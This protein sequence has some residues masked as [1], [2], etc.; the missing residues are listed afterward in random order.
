MTNSEYSIEV[1]IFSHATSH[2]QKTAIID[3]KGD[4]VSYSNLWEN[5]RLAANALYSLGLKKGERIILSASKSV[6]F[7]F[8]Y[9]GAHIL[10]AIV[11]PVDPEANSTRMDRIINATKPKFIFGDLRNVKNYNVVP[12]SEIL[13]QSINIVSLNLP[14]AQQPADIL[15]TTGTTGFPKGVVLT[16]SNEFHAA[17]N[18][19]EFIGNNSDDIE[20]LAL[21]ISHSFG[22]GRIRCTL[23]AGGT[24]V[25]LGSFASMK[26]FF[27]AIENYQVTGFGM[28]PA[29]W[30]YISKMSC[31]KIGNYSQQLKYIEIGSAPMPKSE[32]ERL[33]KLLP[34]TRL[35]MHYG[36]TEASRSA[37]ISFHD[38]YE[39]LDSAGKPT[40]NCEI[41][42]F[43]E[44]GRRLNTGEQ[45]EVCVK[46]EH[47]CADY[48]NNHKE[49]LSD[50]H[51]G[52]FRTGDWGYID[53]DG[54]L[55]LVSRTKELINVG[56]KKVSPMEVEEAL[57]SFEGIDEAACIGAPDPVMGEV[58]VAFVTTPLD[59]KKEHEIIKALS[60]SLENYKVPIA[61]RYIKEL[62]K[63]SSGKLQ[64][65]TLKKE[66][67]G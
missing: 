65:L 20:L 19:N 58:V 1:A 16:S 11:I 34:E 39:H 6:D 24:I 9:F 2:P 51:D 42:I 40:P 3:D 14:I 7:I 22:L 60:S 36:L 26:K 62:P 12:F 32:K 35:C 49:Y 15:F 33:I 44:S 45:G 10:G 67:Y 27:S 48:W 25:I 55:H 53:Q 66:Y 30:A 5:I 59:T 4:R 18:I 46:G 54:Y 13:R 37:F 47:V 28:V 63:T 61:I 41:A 57:E 56:G 29:S 50:F 64:R 23:L 43:S 31:D 17:K 38:E 52:Y 8:L 21:P